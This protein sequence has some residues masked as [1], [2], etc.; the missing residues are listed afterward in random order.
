MKRLST[1]SFLFL[2]VFFN[3]KIFAADSKANWPSPVMDNETFGFLLFDLLEYQTIN[4]SGALNWDVVGWQGNDHHRLWVKTEGEYGLK[5]PRSGEA[6][7]QILYGQPVTSFFDAQIGI[8]AEQTLGERK[9]GPRFSAV[10]GI[11]GLAIY[12]FELE[13]AVFVGKGHLAGRVSGTKDL[14][15][16]Q[17]LIL[18]ARVEANA[19]GES[20]EQFETGA[21]LNDAEFGLRF[22][23]EI[24]REIAPYVGINW[25]NLFGEA[26]DYR[27]R[28]GGQTSEL[29]AVSGLRFWF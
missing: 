6:D 7:L 22:R 16:T 4:N 29:K 24:K 1:F 13:S 18:Q 26:A 21:G 15:I 28:V 14:L 27:S 23:Y 10:F 2:L 5:N 11:Q 9:D 17:K 3:S 8:Q 25:T 12:R 20:S 19:A